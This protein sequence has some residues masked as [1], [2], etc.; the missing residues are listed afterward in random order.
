M[1]IFDDFFPALIFFIAYKIYG[2]YW[3]T[4]TLIVASAV[5][6]IYFQIKYKKIE[7]IYW[8]TF[9]FLLIFGGAT[10]LLHDPKFLIWK[11]SLV[12]WF[13]GTLFLLSHF[14]SKCLLEFLIKAPERAKF[15]EGSLRKINLMW[16]WFFLFLGTLNIYIGYHYPTETWVNFKV[17]GILGLTI[18]FIIAQ[19]LYLQRRFKE[20]P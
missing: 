11:V 10:I 6:L 9:I 16:G 1:R 19:A 8:A 15:P 14:F 13:F 3:A 18:V 20:K 2:I 17:F 7:P 12:N 4:F 5:Q